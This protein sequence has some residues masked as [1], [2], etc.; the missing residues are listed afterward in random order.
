[1]ACNGAFQFM[2]N[3]LMFG[4]GFHYEQVNIQHI[5]DYV[6]GLIAPCSPGNI[7]LKNA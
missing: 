1:M 4:A 5:I 7:M 2:A 6:S 3:R